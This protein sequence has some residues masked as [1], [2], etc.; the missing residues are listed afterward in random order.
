[1]SF[2][3]KALILPIA[4]LS[5]P[6]LADEIQ[7]WI[8]VH[9]DFCVTRTLPRRTVVVECFQADFVAHNINTPSG[10]YISRWDGE[11]S[12]QLYVNGVLKEEGHLEGVIFTL[13][14]D[15][16]IQVNHRDTCFYVAEED[17]Y[18]SGTLIATNGELRHTDRGIVESCDE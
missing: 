3:K 4:L 6:V 16:E 9:D 12:R 8:E 2:Y 17:V 18:V 7:E 5:T 13:T 10:N 14:Q 1:M 15:G 11:R